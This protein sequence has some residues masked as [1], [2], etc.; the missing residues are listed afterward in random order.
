MYFPYIRGKQYELIALRELVES[1]LLSRHIIPIVEP[2]KL[3]PSLVSAMLNY[4]QKEH[5]I[6]IVQNPSVGQFEHDIKN[7]RVNP[8]AR[9]RQLFL[10][11][12]NRNEITKA[13]IMKRDADVIL[14]LWNKQGVNKEETLVINSQRDYLDTY[15]R[16]FSSDIPK[17][18]LIPNDSS[19]DKAVQGKKVL[20]RDRFTKKPRNADY[21]DA[22]DEFFS[23]DHLN[24]QSEGY[25]GF[26]DYSIIGGE[27]Q[28]PGYAAYA[29][30]I[31][32]VYFDD[33]DILRI[34]HFVSD[35]NESIKDQPMKYYQA[36]K[37]LYT[38]HSEGLKPKNEST[39]LNTFLQHY[40]DQSFTNLGV[41]K[42]L[43]IMHH[44]EIMGKHLDSI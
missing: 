10:E 2:I 19:F 30:V 20:F 31:H 43:S 17:Y 21:V 9:Y 29:I 40:K 41:I 23:E 4:I 39:G 5:P 11:H 26:S 18:T 8:D 32:I 28:K 42:K 37:K 16:V 1:D 6:A 27:Y 22:S 34:K 25:E 35:S 44:L 14:K 13:I 12:L 38:W 15:K 36:L 7:A 33:N 3:I 24:Y